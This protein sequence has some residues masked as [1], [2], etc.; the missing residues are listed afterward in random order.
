MAL[1]KRQLQALETG[2]LIVISHIFL[3]LGRPGEIAD[4]CRL[5]ALAVAVSIY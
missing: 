3:N 2:F 4:V 5:N 1:S